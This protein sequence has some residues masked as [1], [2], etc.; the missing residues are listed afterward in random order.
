MARR[1]AKLHISLMPISLSS[2]NNARAVRQTAMESGVN[3][4][5][6]EVMPF[7]L[8]FNLLGSIIAIRTSEI[9]AVL[10]TLT[11]E[12]KMCGGKKTFQQYVA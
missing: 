8:S 1:V 5:T 7:W 3:I 6:L 9:G 12:Q 2:S 4:M 10:A 11:A